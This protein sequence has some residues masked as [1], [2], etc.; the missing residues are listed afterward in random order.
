[1][2]RCTGRSCRPAAMH[3]FGTTR[4]HLAQVAVAAREW[5]L[6]NPK[7]WEK[8]PLTVQD[9]LNARMVSDPLGVRDCCLV[10]DGGGAIIVTSAE[11]AKS[12]KKPRAIDAPAVRSLAPMASSSLTMTNRN[13]V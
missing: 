8:K 3:E 7:A 2:S 13:F 4:E 11:R 10:N 5:A 9:V 12:L 1:M 6:L